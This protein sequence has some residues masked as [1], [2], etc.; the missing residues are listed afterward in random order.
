ML[1]VVFLTRPQ[2]FG[3]FAEMAA[4]AVELVG[5]GAL[6]TVDGLLEIADHEQCPVPPLGLAGAGEEL[7]GQRLDDLPLA[8]VGVLRL[9]D[10]EVIDVAVQ[11]VAHPVPHAGRRQ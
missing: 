4:H 1:G 9:V 3:R 10:Q 11:L 8:G 7:G 5:V 2:D 6:K